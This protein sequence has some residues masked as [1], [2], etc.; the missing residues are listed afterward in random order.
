MGSNDITIKQ[1]QKK[2]MLILVLK[3]KKK[4]KKAAWHHVFNKEGNKF[5]VNI[6]QFI[7]PSILVRSHYDYNK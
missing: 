4:K 7:V 3:K 6:S 2:P 1:K 5:V